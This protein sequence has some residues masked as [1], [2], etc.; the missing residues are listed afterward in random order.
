MI[1]VTFNLDERTVTQIRRTAERLGIAQSQVV[2]HAIAEYVARTD[3]VSERERLRRLTVLDRLRTAPA[4]RSG[5]TVRAELR[6]IRVARRNGGR[7]S[8]R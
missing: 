7:H 8:V 2:R 3:R 1:T 4:S 6:A 5:A